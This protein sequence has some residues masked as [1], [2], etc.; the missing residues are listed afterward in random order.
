[1]L[2]WPREYRPK[3]NEAIWFFQTFSMNL[4]ELFK[5]ED[6]GE[7]VPVRLLEIIFFEY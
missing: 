6:K 3:P 2:K 1:M 5:K 4:T 7:F